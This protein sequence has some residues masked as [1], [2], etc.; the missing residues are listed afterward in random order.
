MAMSTN[1][2]FMTLRCALTRLDAETAAFVQSQSVDAA[3]ESP[4][5]R[6]RAVYPNAKSLDTVS[7][8]S[9]ILLELISEH[10]SLLVKAMTEPIETLSCWTCVRSMLEAS[11]IAGWLLDPGIDGLE[12]VGRAYAH[13]Y[14][15]LVQQ[16]RFARSTNFP[17][18]EVRKVE[19]RLEE[20]VRDAATHGFVPVLDG[21]RRRI[22]VGQKMPGATDI[23]KIVLDED[24]AYRLLS[25]VAHAHNWALLQLGFK[26]LSAPQF[27]TAGGV[28]TTAIEKSAGTVEGYQFLAVLAAKSLALPL[29]YQC[30][31]DGWNK[32]RLVTVL[33][34]VYD[35]MNASPAAR[36]WRGTPV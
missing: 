26:R 6:E 27:Q 8:L 1:E 21:R 4:A 35:Q 23:I 24:S 9:S 25:S 15:G 18:D 16:I 3:P 33:D 22:G 10:V 5:A 34:S 30:L 36:F 12:R 14:E 7:A 2:V 29:W 20:V 13:R 19:D 11:A 28:N 32:V 17:R 31:Y